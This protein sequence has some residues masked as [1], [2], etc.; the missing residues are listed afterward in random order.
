MSS[1]NDLVQ[2]V[3]VLERVVGQFARSHRQLLETLGRQG[4]LPDEAWREVA[5]L[6]T[7]ALLFAAPA[8]PAK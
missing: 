1:Q 7:P 4:V 8:L 2:R 6:L 3:E 5:Q